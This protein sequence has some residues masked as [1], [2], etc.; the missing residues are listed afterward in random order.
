M[1]CYSFLRKLASN[2]ITVPARLGLL[3]SMQS[4]MR[5]LPLSLVRLVGLVGRAASAAVGGVCGHVSMPV[6]L[7]LLQ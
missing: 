3:V 7:P 1:E 6:K 2:F 5:D 4:R